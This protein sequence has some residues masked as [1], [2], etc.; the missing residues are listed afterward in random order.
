MSETVRIAGPIT[1]PHQISLC[2]ASPL[3]CHMHEVDE[4]CI[5]GYRWCM[6]CG[7]AFATAAEL[8]AGHNGH[9][10]VYGIEPETDPG[11][12]FC[13]PLCTHSW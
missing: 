10:A 2:Y 8:L 9:L 5:P 1:G 3:H 7:H 4:P 6:E 12:V 13:C 11:K